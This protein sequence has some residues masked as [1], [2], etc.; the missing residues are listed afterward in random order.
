MIKSNPHAPDPLMEPDRYA[1]PPTAPSWRALEERVAALE[2]HVKALDAWF[3]GEISIR[4]SLEDAASKQRKVNEA[5]LDWMNGD[6]QEDLDARCAALR[7][8]LK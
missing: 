1:L 4:Q 6:V 8:A 2:K 3:K 7:E 5:L